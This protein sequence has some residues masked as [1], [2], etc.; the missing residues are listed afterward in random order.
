MKEQILVQMEREMDLC[1]LLQFQA[2]NHM[3]FMKAMEGRTPIMQKW[4]EELSSAV[5]QLNTSL[6]HVG[7]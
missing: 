3:G 5:D 4:D 6:S 2:Q 7:A 1:R